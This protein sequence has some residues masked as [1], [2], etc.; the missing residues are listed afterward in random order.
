M[1][2]KQERGKNGEL[3]AENYLQQKGYTL[4]ERNYRAG[5][6]EIDLICKKDNTLIF[7][8]V[9]T[10]TSVKFGHPEEFVSDAQIAKIMEGAE[11]FVV[12]MN[13]NGAIRFDIVSVLLQQP[14]NRIEHFKDAFY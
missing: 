3:I 7:I 5:K 10:R 13:W 14:K 12:D 11:V 4:L 1:T 8:E 9:K 2:T 6:S